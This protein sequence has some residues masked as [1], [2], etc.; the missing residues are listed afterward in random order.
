[1]RP[2]EFYDVEKAIAHCERHIERARAWVERR[3]RCGMDAAPARTR[4]TT[5]KQ[6]QALHEHERTRILKQC[7][8]PQQQ[9]G[10]PGT[11]FGNPC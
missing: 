7:E 6:L 8:E 9:S 5:F 11:K 4:L 10:A 2:D 3:E 1:M